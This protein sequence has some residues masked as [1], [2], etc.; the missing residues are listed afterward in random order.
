MVSIETARQHFKHLIR[1]VRGIPIAANIIV[2]PAN[3][4]ATAFHCTWRAQGKAT[5]EITVHL[6][7]GAM[8]SYRE[9]NEDERGAMSTR[10]V[11]F[12]T[13]RIADGGYDPQA[14]TLPAFIIDIDR[15]TP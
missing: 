1:E 4:E 11:K 10:F 13:T 3:G 5:R 8:E 9:A 2:R 7:S 12:V 14:T 15:L 6:H